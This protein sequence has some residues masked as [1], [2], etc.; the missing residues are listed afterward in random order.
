MKKNKSVSEFPTLTGGGYTQGVMD[1]LVR[2][3]EEKRVFIVGVL[4]SEDLIVASMGNETKREF[5]RSSQ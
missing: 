2:Q 1:G 5:G 4:A 3:V